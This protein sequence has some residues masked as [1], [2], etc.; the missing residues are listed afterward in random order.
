MQNPR[1]GVEASG[2][3]ADLALRRPLLPMTR[4]ERMTGL[5]LLLGV[6]LG[7]V[8]GNPAWIWGGP[9]R[10]AWIYYGFFRFAPVYL[11]DF[12]TL[13]Y[14][15]RL[16]VILP[17]HLLR[18]LLPPVPANLVLHLTFYTVA[19]LAL[20]GTVRL[21]FG[22][23]PALLAA[24]A[25]AVHPS[26]MVSIGRD[27]VDG[28]GVTYALLA[29]L[30]LTLAARDRRWWIWQLLAGGAVAALISANLFYGLSAVFLA[31]YFL[32]L[33]YRS[34]ERS[35]WLDAVCFGMGALG[36]FTALSLIGHFC[37]GSRLNFLA[38]T[39][40]FVRGFVSQPSVF[41][42]P[43]SRFLP[44]AGWL[45]FPVLV[46]GGS[47]RLAFREPDL[48]RRSVQLLFIAFFGAMFAAQM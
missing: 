37:C 22:N 18:A 14:S 33:T 31:L 48:Q 24:T 8:L 15:S 29:L 36:A 11:R 28:F 47:L 25:F 41:K 6:P 44:Y 12:N 45:V 40:E 2:T 3:G 30:F 38:A 34:R 26:F 9:A 32:G 46:A 19:V 16:S 27:M 43:A 35:L 23:G 39:V 42:L 5:L 7:L 10:D 17:G 1:A 13:Y 21:L 4:W 20:W